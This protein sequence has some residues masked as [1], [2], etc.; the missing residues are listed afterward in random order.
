MAKR[1]SG[2]MKKSFAKIYAYYV[3]NIITCTFIPMFML[4][5]GAE[6]ATKPFTMAFSNTPGVLKKF[7]YKETTTLG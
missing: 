3:L 1:V 4:K 6:K 7:Q 2:D 5:L